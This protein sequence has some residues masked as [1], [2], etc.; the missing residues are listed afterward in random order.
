[1][2]N[3]SHIL[4][5]L[6]IVP[7]S[8]HKTVAPHAD[9]TDI[10]FVNT[11]LNQPQIDV[12]ANGVLQYPQLTFP[13]S[14]GYLSIDAPINRLTLANGADTL[15]SSPTAFNPG[16]R[17]SIFLWDTSATALHLSA[18][19]DSFPTPHPG[20]ALLR[21]LNF[22]PSV[23]SVDLYSVTG[24]QDLFTGRYF[25]QTDAF[26]ASFVSFPA[27]VYNLELRSPGTI[28]SIATLDGLTLVAGKAYTLFARGRVG[29][30]GDRT[31]GIG[32]IQH[33]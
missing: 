32:V 29:V 2:R 27:G 23:E 18:V 10:L 13:D 33:N 28:I 19:S 12:Y 6:L 20:Y 15:I 7:L 5:I 30:V 25:D 3:L 31:L 22:S 26:A 14:T 16:A 9:T 1:M 4:L 17:Y 21:F 8:C 24:G 11:S